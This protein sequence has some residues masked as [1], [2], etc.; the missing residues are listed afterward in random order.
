[1]SVQ[2]QV[3]NLLKELQIRRGLTYIFISHDLSVVKFMSDVMCVMKDGIIVEKG[4]SDDIYANPD[5]QYTRELISA[6][7]N[8]DIAHIEAL[9]QVRDDASAERLRTALQP[10]GAISI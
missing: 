3:L 5:Q 2:A 6:I 1:M 9:Q 8:D 10:T 4:P 7:P